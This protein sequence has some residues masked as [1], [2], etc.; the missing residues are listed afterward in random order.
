VNG[1]EEGIEA[2]LVPLLLVVCFFVQ[3]AVMQVAE[4]AALQ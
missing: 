3:R 2:P 4:T 1:R